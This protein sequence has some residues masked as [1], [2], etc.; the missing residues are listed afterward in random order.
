MQGGRELEAR[1]AGWRFAVTDALSSPVVVLTARRNARAARGEACGRI[2][3]LAEWWCGPT[4]AH[5]VRF[6]GTFYP[7][8]AA[9]KWLYE[10]LAK[11]LPAAPRSRNRER[12]GFQDLDGALL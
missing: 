8:R 10:R 5:E 9:A 6:D 7:P 1:K 2:L 12:I 4:P 3:G 11:G